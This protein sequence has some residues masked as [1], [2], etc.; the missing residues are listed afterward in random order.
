[1]G[2]QIH[3]HASERVRR[4]LLWRKKLHRLSE[5]AQLLPYKLGQVITNSAPASQ[6]EFPTP[7]L[8]FI[9]KYHINI[10]LRGIRWVFQPDS[11]VSA[12]HRQLFRHQI[13][14]VTFL[15]RR[16]CICEMMNEDLA[17]LREYARSN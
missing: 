13:L 17:L 9:R 16:K 1:M 2:N 7:P 10:D 4:P 8:L 14:T 15:P 3:L 12:G 5:I 6:A 11:L